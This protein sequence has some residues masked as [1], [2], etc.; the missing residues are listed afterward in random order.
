MQQSNFGASLF[1][2][3]FMMGFI[4]GAIMMIIVLSLARPYLPMDSM[5]AKSLVFAPLLSAFLWGWRVATFGKRYQLGLAAAIK[6]SFI[7][8]HA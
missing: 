8:Y 4:I 1:F 2:I 5:W 3:Y 7:G 6:A